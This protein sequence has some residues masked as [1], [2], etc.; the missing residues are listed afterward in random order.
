[1]IEAFLLVFRKNSSNIAIV[2]TISQALTR[3]TS[4]QNNPFTTT[5]GTMNPPQQLQRVNQI[6]DKWYESES[7]RGVRSVIALT[8]SGGVISLPAAWLRAEKRIAVTTEGKCGFYEIKP[9][10][11]QFQTGGPG[12]FDVTKGCLGVAIDLGDNTNGVRQYQLTGVVAD[13][14]A[15]SYSAVLRKRYVYATDTSTVVI[16]DCFT[17]L[18]ISVRAMAASDANAVELSNGLWAE[19][20]AVLDSGLGQFEAGNDFGVLET[21]PMCAQ[22]TLYNAI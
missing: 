14:D 11:Y 2:F 19:A 4:Q 15:L 10:G 5:Y 7:W 1:M 21:D 16:P 6:L 8:S 20:F 9:L 22:G 18:E 12:Y 3:L 17:A 13:L